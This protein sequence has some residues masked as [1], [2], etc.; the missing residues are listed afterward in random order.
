VIL[1]AGGPSALRL[2]LNAPQRPWQ[3]EIVDHLLAVSGGG[4]EAKTMV[5]SLEDDSLGIRCVLI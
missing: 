1:A 2:V 5:T 3:D 4:L